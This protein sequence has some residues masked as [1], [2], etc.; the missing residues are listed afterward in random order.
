MSFEKIAKGIIIFMLIT[1]II[2]GVGYTL[3]ANQ[4]HIDGQSEYSQ[5]G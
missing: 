5:Q 4:A 2:Y 3:G 1:V